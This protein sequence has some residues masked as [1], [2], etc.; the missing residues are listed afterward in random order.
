MKKLP[1][2]FITGLL[3]FSCKPNH[4]K[5]APNNKKN[6]Q[7]KTTTSENDLM[8]KEGIDKFNAYINYLNEKNNL[9]NSMNYYFE[10]VDK[11]GTPTYKSRISISSLSFY[12]ME[13]LEEKVNLSPSFGKLDGD[14][15]EQIKV[16][17]S[18]EKNVNKLY[19]Y[20]SIKEY[21]SD[22]FAKAKELYPL[23]LEDYKKFDVLDL[24]IE[25]EIAVYQK[26]VREAELEN[27]KKNGYE[28]S[29]AKVMFID[30]SRE[31]LE[32]VTTK[33]LYTISELDK[34]KVKTLASKVSS[35]FL[36]FTEKTENEE[37][38]KK[39]FGR[40]SSLSSF[41]RDAQNYVSQCRTLQQILDDPEEQKKI[42]HTHE[43]HR[44]II[45]PDGTPAKILEDFN[46]MIGFSS[47]M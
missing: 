19:E 1:I 4:E 27:F 45:V 26:K 33:D 10:S 31:F 35:D 18:L 37:Q 20:N 16:Y 29:Y 23:I 7:T 25:E 44:G 17:K 28:I 15:K 42:I 3:L 34:E 6:S 2:F 30:S 40:F 13:K 9:Y 8:S 39:E 47:R 5:T 46:K 41:K 36:S 14:M 38:L 22:D 24:L 32:Y 43:F 11:T 12:P 21:L